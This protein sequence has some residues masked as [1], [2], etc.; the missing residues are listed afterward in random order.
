METVA[1]DSSPMAAEWR[2]FVD[3]LVL[4][5]VTGRGVR[6]RIIATAPLLSARRRLTLPE[7]CGSR[8]HTVP[9]L[10]LFCLAS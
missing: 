4:S 9:T 6:G 8:G 7:K 3:L 2:V 1:A 10:T 5:S